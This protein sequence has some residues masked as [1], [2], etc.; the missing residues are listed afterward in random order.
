MARFGA[1]QVRRYAGLIQDYTE[2]F[3]R[4]DAAGHPRRRVRLRGPPRRRRHLGPARSGS[5]VRIDDPRRPGGR[6]LQ[7]LLA[8]DRGRGQRQ[9]RHHLRRPSSTS[10][11]RLVEEDIPF[12]TGLM[13]P[14]DDR[15][16]R[17]ARS[18]TPSSRPPCAGG[19]RRD[20]PAH[21]RRPARRPG[22]GRPRTHPGRQP[23]HDEQR[24]LRR[25]RSR[26]GSGTSPTTRRSAAAWAPAR[27][28]PGSSGVHTHMTNSLNTPVEALEN[29]LPLRIRSLRPAPGLGRPRP[30]S[31]A[32]RA[33][34]GS[35]NSASRPTL[36]VMSERRRF[37]PYGGRGGEPGG[38]GPER[39][40]SPRG[41]TR[42]LG[43]KVNVKLRP[44]R[45][46]PDRDAGRRRATAGRGRSREGGSR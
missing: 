46:P 25:L 18:S 40:S 5:R 13:R 17:R 35:T 15:R 44:G 24:R 3:L 20:L 23:G 45:R 31:A 42:S 4:A 12:N 38:Q 26:A 30:P 34:S 11:A 41:R 10:S 8:P 39:A 32:A 36:T 14:L 16:A 6:R 2:R 37:A 29:Y 19:Q 9:L 33:S 28:P 7:R 1:G 43:G 27:R 22:Q 21:R